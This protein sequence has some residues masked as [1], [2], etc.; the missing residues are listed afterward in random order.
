[1]FKIIKNKV[2]NKTE[3]LTEADI[4]TITRYFEML[5]TNKWLKFNAMTIEQYNRAI[6]FEELVYS[7]LKELAVPRKQY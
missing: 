3:Y 5:D 2:G 7:I 6:G 4:K 1:M